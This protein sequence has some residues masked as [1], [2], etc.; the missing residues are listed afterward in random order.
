MADPLLSAYT[1][2]PS[3]QAQQQ[4]QQQHGTPHLSPLTTGSPSFSAMGGPNTAQMNG[5]GSGSGMVQLLPSSGQ[6]PSSLGGGGPAGSPPHHPHSHHARSQSTFVPMHSPSSSMDTMGLNMTSV[7]R[8]HG[9]MGI[10]SSSSAASSAAAAAASSAA[11][12]A[13]SAAGILATTPLAASL[14]SPNGGALSIGTAAAAALPG[15]SDA[16]SY[17]AQADGYDVYAEIGSGAFST[18]YRG[19]VRESGEEVAIK[20]IDLDLFN[21]NWDEIRR[22]ILIMSQLQHPNVVRLKTAFVDGQDL[23]IVMHFAEAGSAAAIMKELQPHDSG[24]Q[25]IKDE[26]VI[27]TILKEVLQ[28]LAYF[29]KHGSIHRDVKAGNILLTATGDVLLADFGVAGTLMEGGDRKKNRQTF[30]GTPCWMAPGSQ[31]RALRQTH[32]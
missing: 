11:A 10:P 23:W 28:A 24:A 1:G 18:V 25:G 6:G 26:V 8:L 16:Y 5:G 17:P 31:T 14:T 21:T 13:S 12:A 7:S 2:P 3:Q 32:K 29:H 9:S 19:V 15:V 4:Q 20:V 22:E 27:A 30:T